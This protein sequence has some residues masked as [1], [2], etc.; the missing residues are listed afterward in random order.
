MFMSLKK[1]ATFSALCLVSMT[2][3]SGEF[4]VTAEASPTSG[5]EVAA[6]LETAEGMI[7]A[8]YSF[9]A[10]RLQ[11]FLSQAGDSAARILG[12]QAWAEGGNY[13]V[14]DRMPCAPEEGGTIACPV[15]VQDDLVQALETGF[16]VTDT[17]HLTFANG[18]IVNVETSSN[19]QPIYHDAR[20]WVRESMP[21]VMEGPCKS[22]DGLRVTPG[23][24]AK[25]MA[26]GY[27]KYKQYLDALKS[28][29]ADG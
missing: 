23:D 11:P 19:D 26:V 8:F 6:N 20:A 27:A 10:V 7:D 14:L 15:T 9:D 3:C 5:E 21:E 4:D 16:D 2:A 24:C 1:R 18:V 28:R 29:A 17:F 13:E 25:A 22:I 12:Y